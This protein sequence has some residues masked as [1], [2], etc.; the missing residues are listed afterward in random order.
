M[1]RGLLPLLCLLASC[2]VVQ[3]TKADFIF[4]QNAT[5]AV[6]RV[7]D[8]DTFETMVDAD[9]MTVRVLN[10]DTFESRRGD[11]LNTQS[12]KAGITPNSALLLGKQAKSF[13]DSLLRGKSVVIQ[14]QTGQPNFDVFGRLLRVVSIDGKEYPALLRARGFVVP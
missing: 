10:V 2:S 5:V 8:A 4:A 3:S 1:T 6:S 9:T 13:A 7:V 14:R 12:A 11:R